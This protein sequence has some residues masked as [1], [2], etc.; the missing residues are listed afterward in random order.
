MKHVLPEIIVQAFETRDR[1][2]TTPPSVPVK[3]WI[4]ESLPLTSA[5]VE[6]ETP[7]KRNF[8]INDEE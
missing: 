4:V 3:R 2:T 7:R 5:A 1:I 8:E 6:I